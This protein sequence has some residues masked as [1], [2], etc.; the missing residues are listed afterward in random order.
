MEGEGEGLGNRDGTGL[1]RLLE[2]CRRVHTECR[3]TT[4]RPLQDGCGPAGQSERG[5]RDRMA[6]QNALST[7]LLFLNLRARWGHN[8]TRREKEDL[9]IVNG[10]IFAQ[11][12]AS[13]S[14]CRSLRF[15]P[16]HLASHICSICSI[17]SNLSLSLFS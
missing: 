8:I 10:D 1:S 13:F 11:R 14:L 5:V 17:F 15:I 6:N 9:I 12:V 16:S 4:K 2:A 7:R 3:G